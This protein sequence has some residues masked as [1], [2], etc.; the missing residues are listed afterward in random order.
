[1]AVSLLLAILDQI[2]IRLLIVIWNRIVIQDWSF[3]PGNKGHV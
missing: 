3:D 1:M 2:A